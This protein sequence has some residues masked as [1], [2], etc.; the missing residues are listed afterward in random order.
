M[1]TARTHGQCPTCKHYG[2]NC[3]CHVAKHTPGPWRATQAWSS[4]QFSKSFGVEAPAPEG[5]GFPT[6]SATGF[7]AMALP[8]PHGRD[9]ES[10]AVQEANA[11]LIAAAPELLAA[12][13]A[14][15]ADF[16]ASVVTT[17]PMLIEARAAI[18]KAE[19]A[20]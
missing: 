4:L 7:Y 8:P 14:L 2:S 16:D 17:D 15:V 10:R 9:P 20:E 19:G 5:P 13:K 11:R 3:R 6:A 1:S 12:L 18:A